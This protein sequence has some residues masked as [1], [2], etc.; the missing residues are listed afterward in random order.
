MDK[1]IAAMHCPFKI[2][3]LVVL[4]I[5]CNASVVQMKSYNVIL[6]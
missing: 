1:S 4:V 3:V 6:S 5:E 2:N